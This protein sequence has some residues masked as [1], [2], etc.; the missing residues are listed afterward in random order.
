MCSANA[1]TKTKNEK[2]Q[3]KK[4]K[5]SKKKSIMFPKTEQKQKQSKNKNKKDCHQILHTASIIPADMHGT[6]PFTEKLLFKRVRSGCFCVCV[7]FFYS[8]LLFFFFLVVI[9][10]PLPPTPTLPHPQ[11][12]R[13]N[14]S[15]PNAGDCHVPVARN[16]QLGIAASTRVLSLLLFLCPVNVGLKSSA[17]MKSFVHWR[18][19]RSL[20]QLFWIGER[21][22]AGMIN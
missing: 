17:I 16:Y 8:Y 12:S 11:V 4:I 14:A 19:Q 7:F 15:T 22:V 20:W 13:D 5:K 6:Q 10:H 1:K 21:V 3:R 18:G 9:P 2:Q